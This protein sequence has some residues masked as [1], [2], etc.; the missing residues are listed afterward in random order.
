MTYTAYVL[1][2]SA[3]EELKQ[4]FT[5]KYSKFIGHHV[6]VEF[7]VDPSTPPPED[8][9]V[10]VIGYVDS[11]D[12]LEVLV[13]MVNGKVGRNDGGKYHITWSL[14]PQKY[15]P[16]DSN[17]VL[18]EFGFTLVMPIKIETEPATLR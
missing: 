2:D 3:R 11:G 18:S 1:T 8:A 14:D 13:V 5:P 7:G 10:K 15:S 12:G 9:S 6:T 4:R 17:T 16:K